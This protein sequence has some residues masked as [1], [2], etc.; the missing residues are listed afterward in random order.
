MPHAEWQIALRDAIE[1]KFGSLNG[2]ARHLAGPGATRN[3][4]DAKRRPMMKWLQPDKPTIPTAES[5]A[6]MIADGVDVDPAM[7]P[8]RKEP[9]RYTDSELAT[10]MDA[11]LENQERMW[12][13]LLL[14]ANAVGELGASVR[15]L[16]TLLESQSTVPR[17]A[18]RNG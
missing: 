8:T 9:R 11:A 4:V 2:Y 15:H 12:A 16:R 17:R 3:Q 6:K 14:L 5:V 10:K 7:F 1:R 18:G 13:Q